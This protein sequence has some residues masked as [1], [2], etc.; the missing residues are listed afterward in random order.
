M[1]IIEYKEGGGGGAFSFT[2]QLPPPTNTTH[3]AAASLTHLLFLHRL[4]PPH[5]PA[6]LNQGKE[7]VY[8]ANYDT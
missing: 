5:S 6:G 3:S 1:R 7:V 8:V 4:R 2:P